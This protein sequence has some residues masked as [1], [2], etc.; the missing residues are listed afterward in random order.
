MNL[1]RQSSKLPALAVGLGAL[2]L[3]APGFACG[4]TDAEKSG[5]ASRIDTFEFGFEPGEA[6]IPAGTTVEWTNTGELTHNVK[7]RGYFSGALE[8]GGS[9]RHEFNRPGRHSY[10]CT[11][12][13]QTMRGSLVVRE[14]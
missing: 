7:G 8:P 13:P 5:G 4:G 6:R 1:W 10:V 2:I 12:H 14:E 11:L 9:Y 3:S